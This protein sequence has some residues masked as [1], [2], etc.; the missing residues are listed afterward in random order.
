MDQSNETRK[1][2]SQI[3]LSKDRSSK[4]CEIR[5]NYWVEIT[6]NKINNDRNRQRNKNI[7]DRVVG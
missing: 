1:I 6:L 7:L 5:F 4:L 3:C 2:V